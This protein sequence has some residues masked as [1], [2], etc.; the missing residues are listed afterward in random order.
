[1]PTTPAR[2][3]ALIARGEEILLRR[4]AD[5]SLTLP[6]GREMEGDTVFTS[7]ELK[8]GRMAQCPPHLV[9]LPQREGCAALTA[10][11]YLLAAKGLELLNWDSATRFCASCGAHLEK[12]TEISRRCPACGKE[13]FPPLAPAIVVLV[14][15]GEEALLVQTRAARR[16]YHALVAGFVET[17][18]SLEQCVAREV[19][20][21][22]SLDITNIRYVGSQSWP[23]PGQL[24]VGFTAK[25]AGGEIFAAD[26]ELAHAAFYSRANAPQ[27]PPPPSLTNAIITAWLEGRDPAISANPCQ[28]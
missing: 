2:Q 18:E 6:E 16:P 3:R 27:I 20:E 13:Y 26:G 21:E 25:Y 12:A 19:K 11:E 28:S 14:M 4:K 24:M 8:V 23:F 22:T 17:G 1:M 5:G 15:K 9:A 10:E 7:A